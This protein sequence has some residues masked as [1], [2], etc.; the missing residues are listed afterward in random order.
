MRNSDKTL[1]PS[2]SSLSDLLN[3]NWRVLLIRSFCEIL[4][5]VYF[6]FELEL[7]TSTARLI[8]I[9]KLCSDKRNM[10]GPTR[11]NVDISQLLWY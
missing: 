1:Q 11:S 7:L 4:T 5:D 9:C 6:M 3:I 10:V 8:G 2:A